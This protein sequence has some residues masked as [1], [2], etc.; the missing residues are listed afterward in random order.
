MRI[1]YLHN[2]LL[3]EDSELVKRV[4]I[5]QKEN[6]YKGDWYNMLQVDMALLSFSLSESEMAIATSRHVKNVVNS[7]VK[8]QLSRNLNPYK[9]HTQ[10]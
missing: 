7:C 5:A 1:N 10:K 8:V 4:Y 6:P 9:Q 2:I 3:R